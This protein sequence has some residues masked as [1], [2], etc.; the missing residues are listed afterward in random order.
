MS[1]PSLEGCKQSLENY[2]LN[3]LKRNSWNRLGNW[4]RQPTSQKFWESNMSVPQSSSE[5]SVCAGCAL[6]RDEVHPAPVSPRW[7]PSFVRRQTSQQLTQVQAK[8]CRCWREVTNSQLWVCRG[9]WYDGP[10]GTGESFP[11]L[12]PCLEGSGCGKL[13]RYD[14]IFYWVL[15][16]CQALTACRLVCITIQWGRY[17]CF[18]PFYIWGSQGREVTCCAQGH[19]PSKRSGRDVRPG[20]LLP[21]IALQESAILLPTLLPVTVWDSMSL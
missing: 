6:G 1:L 15:I 16:W 21:A 13:P 19:S 18:P 20:S 11:Q 2:L 9:G 12:R 17:R 10:P 3:G 5:G 14:N 4:V 8:R 7:D